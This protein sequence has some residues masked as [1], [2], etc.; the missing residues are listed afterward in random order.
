MA[1]WSMVGSD[2]T[3]QPDGNRKDD[4]TSVDY[5][6]SSRGGRGIHYITDPLKDEAIADIWKPV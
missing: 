3:G 2:Y 4:T 6:P 1:G 5:H